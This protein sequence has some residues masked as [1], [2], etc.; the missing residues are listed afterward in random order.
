MLAGL[1]RVRQYPAG[2]RIF[3]EGDAP[4]HFYVTVSGRVRISKMSPSGKEFVVAY[5]GPGEMFAEVA[6]FEGKTYPAGAQAVAASTLIAISKDEFTAFLSHNPGVALKIINLLGGR[7]REAL[8][9]LR[10]LA[11][12]RVE[13]RIAGILL[14]LSA[15]L[16]PVLPFTRQE[17]ADMS[18]TTT[19]T[20]IRVMARLKEAGLIRSVRGRITIADEKG[21][22]LLGDGQPLA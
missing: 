6:V 19:E 2:G 22:R 20:A 7:L 5:F 9:R 12:E 18:G 14:M 11:G 10:D 8:N 16:G 21:L 15:R 4:D 13:Q 17:I 3:W 1:A